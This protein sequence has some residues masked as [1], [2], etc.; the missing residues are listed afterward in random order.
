MQKV[1]LFGLSILNV[2]KKDLFAFLDDFLSSKKSSTKDLSVPLTIFTPNPEQIVLAKHEIAFANYLEQADYLLPDGIGLVFAAKLFKFFGKIENSITERIPGVEVVEHLLNSSHFHQLNLKALIIGGRDY[3]R[4]AQEKNDGHLVKIRENLYWTQAYQ[5]KAHKLPV[6]EAA[7][8]Q[9]VRD[10]QPDLVFVAL[11]APDQEEWLI[12]H[13]SLLADNQV[14]IAMSV[15]GSFDFLFAK[16]SRAPLALRKMGLE[17]FWRLIQQ[18]WRLR[19][20]LRLVEFVYL[21]C[22]EIRSLPELH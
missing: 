3:H 11:G 14:K 17:W 12:K 1:K 9:I 2:S 5:D 10:L 16:V 20:Q 22:K 6:E 4:S 7:L 8:E 18:P 21:S 15:G 19:R 13:C